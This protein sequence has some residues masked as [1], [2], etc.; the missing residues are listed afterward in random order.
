MLSLR[1]PADGGTAFLPTAEQL[2]PLSLASRLLECESLEWF[3]P[4]LGSFPPKKLTYCWLQKP[5]CLQS[6]GVLWEKV[7]LGDDSIFSFHYF[8]NE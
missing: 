1:S 2:C 8:E 7:V 4:S 5:F 6:H 3:V